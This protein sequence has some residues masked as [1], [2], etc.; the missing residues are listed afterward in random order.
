MGQKLAKWAARISGI[1]GLTPL[2]QTLLLNM[3]VVARDPEANSQGDGPPC[4]C[5]LSREKIAHNIYGTTDKA[6]NLDR[7]V[8]S[9]RDKGIIEPD[10]KRARKG[11][12]QAYRLNID[13]LASTA[14][15]SLVSVYPNEA[16]ELGRIQRRA[17]A[18]S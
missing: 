4:V 18:Q 7:V 15:E 12:T 2:E 14:Y 5:W 9:L 1:Y 13:I 6:H 8:K 3:A 10:G 17:H 16:K 11:L